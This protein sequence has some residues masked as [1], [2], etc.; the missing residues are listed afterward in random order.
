MI[1]PETSFPACWRDTKKGIPPQEEPPGGR[2][3][4]KTEVRCR[5]ILGH[6]G[7]IAGRP[8]FREDGASVQGMNCVN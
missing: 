5:S 2:T 8:T 4:K 7:G 6:L 1:W 3:E